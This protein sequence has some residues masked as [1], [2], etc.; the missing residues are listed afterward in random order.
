MPQYTMSQL[1]Q[2]LGQR[3]LGMLNLLGK[4]DE[5]RPMIPSGWQWCYFKKGIMLQSVGTFEKDVDLIR[6]WNGDV[7]IVDDWRVYKGQLLHKDM[8]WQGLSP[9]SLQERFDGV[10]VEPGVVMCTS[11]E[12]QGVQFT[13][14]FQC[15]CPKWVDVAGTPKNSLQ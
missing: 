6:L 1:I 8:S 13:F 9:E 10:Q 7:D 11:E 14:T 4:A 12:Y 3:E 5:K 2:L 15:G